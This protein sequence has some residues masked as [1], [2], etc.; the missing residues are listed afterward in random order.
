MSEAAASA[1][2]VNAATRRFGLLAWGLA[3]LL[4]L[5]LLAWLPYQHWDFE[6]R[7]SLLGGILAKARQDSE[8]IFCLF[9]PFLVGWLVWRLRAELARLPLQ[10]SWMGLP[11]LLLGM[12]LYWFGYKA[13][14]AYPGYVAIQLLI[15]GMILQVG[16]RRW[17]ARLAFPWAFLVFMWPMLPLESLLAFPLRGFT[18]QFS[19]SLLNLF[20]MD[21]VR[22][23]TALHSAADAL[24]GLEQ[25]ALFR[26]DVEEPCSGIRSLFS[27]LMISALYGWL[28]LR[29]WGAR[30]LLF[31]S[32]IPLAVLG[33][34]VRMALL[35]VGSRWFGVEF[36]VG[37]NFDGHQEMSFFHTFAGFAVFGV[38]LVG[39]FAL[40]SL[41]EARG[42]G[43]GK[44][45]AA[46]PA[47]V[48][49]AANGR[50]T[51]PAHLV[52][53][54]L[55]AGG[56]LAS[57]LLADT[58]YA[59]A[60]PGIG[61]R[62][63]ARH[64]GFESVDMPMSTLERQILHEDVTIGRR[65][66][67]TPERA[68]LASVVMSGV[69]K[70]SLHEPQV[71]LPG[72]GWI[73]DAKQLVEIDAGLEQP[74]QATLLS[75]HRDAQTAEGGVRRTRALNV[76]WYFGSDG[77]TAAS[78]NRHVTLS[79]LDSVLRN[80][81]HRWALVSFFAPLRDQ[82]IGQEDLFAE[83]T[84]LEEVKIFIRS[85]VPELVAQAKAGEARP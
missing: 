83:V 63:P 24:R 15:L 58:G 53:L 36:A 9:V 46:V 4:L 38:A 12:G 51:R 70:R 62:L 14:T 13:D 31:S 23:G 43:R 80:L 60:A 81:H 18:A 59:V 26:L 42:R 6:R 44:S 75:M 57:C 66:Y 25:G 73:I 82:A 33:N 7:S 30:A 1:I 28:S 55:I 29:T 8:W 27:L 50:P 64:A 17:F 39:M 22:D 19:A 32:A 65:F 74:V 34:V 76:Y 11:P 54:A 48:S 3:G 84:A 10:G 37:R 85:L 68:I 20:G 40:S 49:H 45:R 77:T 61:T 69:I 35:T 67:T 2:P 72:Q 78:Y 47:A 41:L 16:G 56:G 71:C 79:Y 21:V 52:A 5:L